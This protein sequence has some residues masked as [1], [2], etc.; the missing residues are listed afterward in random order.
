[1]ASSVASGNVGDR[2]GDDVEV[3]RAFADKSF[4]NRKRNK[5]RSG[6]YQ[7]REDEADG[8][9]VGLTP[10]DAVK[11]LQINYGYCSILVGSVHALPYNLEVRVDK[12]DPN[13][14]FICNLP[15]LTFSDRCR[16]DA[17]LIGGELARRSKVITCDTYIPNGHSVPSVD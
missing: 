11:Y 6:A 14:A 15:L 1:M 10:K 12:R 9:S 5:V 2:L 16:E 4:R 17:T 7:L 3:F 8:L 13:H